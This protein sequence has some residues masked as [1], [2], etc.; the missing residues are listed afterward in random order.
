MS[1]YRDK[2]GHTIDFD[3]QRLAARL[4]GGEIAVCR[5]AGGQSNPTYFVEHRGRR[6]VL[7]KPPSGDTLPSAHAVDREYRIMAALR[8]TGFPVPEMILLEQDPEPIGTPFYLMERLEGRVF[9]DSALPG[10]S[11]ADRR[12]MWRTT[13][14]TLARLHTTDWQAIGL[15]DFGRT[16]GYFARQ[17]ARWTRQWQLSQTREDANIEALSAW[18]A[19][20]IPPDEH[21]SIVHGDFRIGN[22]MFAPDTAEIAG[23]LDWELSTLGHPLAD[24]AHL[25]TFW[26]FAP[27]ELGG[28]AGLDHAAMGLPEREAFFDDY[29]AAGGF[30]A[31]VTAFH[32]AFALF[33]FAVIFEGIA[34]RHRSG[35]AASP[36][37]MRVGRLSAACAARAID[38]LSR[39]GI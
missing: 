29:Q 11:A 20:N 3:P 17:V 37:A 27:D 31:P 25:G 9:H 10:L 36:D 35:I 22:I 26:D 28:I 32:R 18:L 23:V 24:V 5:I 8:P 33:R 7:R 16:G 6:M 1:R 21:T 12:A 38:I 34:A 19:A 4:G 39:D 14:R 13:A 30:E 2:V 15:G